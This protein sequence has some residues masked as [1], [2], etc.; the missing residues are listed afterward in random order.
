[1][2]RKTRVAVPWILASLVAQMLL[3]SPCAA[4]AFQPGCTLPYDAIKQHHPI[5]SSCD[6]EGKPSASAKAKLQNKAKNDFCES[7]SPASVTLATFTKLQAASDK[8]HVHFGPM[9]LPADRSVLHNL[10]TTTNGVTIGEGSLVRFVGF[11]HHAL[12]SD[13]TGG[14]SCN[15]NQPGRENNDVHI[16]LVG[17]S[18]D[19]P[20]TGIVAEMSPHFRPVS[21][22]DRAMNATVA[23]PVRVT[24]PLFFDSVHLLCKNGKQAGSNPPRR[25][26]W[27][28]HPVYS[29]DV[30]KHTAL[31]DCAATD[32]TA[33]EPLNSQTV[34]AVPH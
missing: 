29:C 30:C 12:Y 23:H 19:N 27:E 1:M 4:A 24:G 32:N 7:G 5:D 3:G 22:T 11:V 17:A 26:L 9:A 2:D 31:A 21:W 6:R 14:E 34:V 10:V 15:C 13:T 28:I 18:G 33:W 25:A 8:K 20:C 16:Y